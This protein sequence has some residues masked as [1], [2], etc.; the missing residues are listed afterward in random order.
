MYHFVT[1]REKRSLS[2]FSKGRKFNTR[3]YLENVRSVR[4]KKVRRWDYS[5]ISNFGKVLTIFRQE[6]DTVKVVLPRMH[7]RTL[8]LMLE[9]QLSPNGEPALPLPRGNVDVCCGHH[10]HCSE[11]VAAPPVLFL[12]RKGGPQVFPAE[13]ADVSLHSAL[14]KPALRGKLGS[15]HLPVTVHLDNALLEDRIRGKYVF[16]SLLSVIFPVLP[17]GKT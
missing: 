3:N 11:A 9:A 12:E 7:T 8:L 2:R 13:T 17:I 6:D 1:R 16:F 5:K 15:L 4:R 14:W 10:P